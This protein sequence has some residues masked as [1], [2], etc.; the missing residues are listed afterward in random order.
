MMAMSH[1]LSPETIYIVVKID[2]DLGAR[3]YDPLT[4]R[5]ETIPNSRDYYEI[6]SENK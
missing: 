2:E 4:N 6:V 3:I 1:N 5:Y